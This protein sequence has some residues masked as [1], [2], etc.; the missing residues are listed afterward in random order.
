MKSIDAPPSPAL[1]VGDL[2]LVIALASARTTAKAA[3]L[4]HLS[5][6]AVS[7]ALIA[8]EEKLGA[9]LFDRTPR[10]LVPTEA[11]SRLAAEAMPLLVS[12]ADLEQR[13]RAPIAAPL[14]LRVVCECYTAYH[15]LP[16]VLVTL[17]ETLPNLRVD[18]RVEHTSTPAQA[19]AAG[20]IDVALLTTSRAPRGAFEE[21]TLFEDEV[22][23]LVSP[24][25]PLAKK[26]ALTRG[27]LRTSTIL[28]S[29]APAE[30]SRW[31]MTRVFGRERPRLRFERLPLTEA[32]LDMT[33][34]GLGIAVL[35]E[36]IA[37]PHLGRGDLVAKR[38]SSGPLLRPWRIAYRREIA[39]AAE[40]LRGALQATVPHARLV[41]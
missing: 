10:G 32:I 26:K 21:R 41:G 16:S 9:R 6:P 23:F 2:R 37:G 8:A 1:D 36:W 15:W 38:L 14:R 30:E 17:R 35:S 40:R 11:G 12:L 20:D 25:H 29:R 28:T 3:S 18:L 24:S 13:A 5:Q 33:R 19:L 34:S 22:V 4:L 27:D 7:R 31:F 39:A